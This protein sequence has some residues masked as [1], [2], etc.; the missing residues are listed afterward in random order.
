[1]PKRNRKPK[2]DGSLA[3]AESPADKVQAAIRPAVAKARL[4]RR[5][6]KLVASP[7]D[8]APT[9]VGDRPRA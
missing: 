6:R 1:M 7:N 8:P 5:G 4:I 2:P 9:G 3:D